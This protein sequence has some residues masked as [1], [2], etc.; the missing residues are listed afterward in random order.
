MSKEERNGVSLKGILAMQKAGALKVDIDN[1]TL[2]GV[3]MSKEQ[4]KAA[5]ENLGWREKYLKDIELINKT[6]KFLRGMQDLVDGKFLRDCLIEFYNYR[7]AN[8][9]DCY[10]RIVL[11][12][13]KEKLVIIYNMPSAGSK[14]VLYNSRV[15]ISNPVCK[16][17]KLSK[18]VGYINSNFA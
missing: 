3:K 8:S 15:D 9:L 2:A 1:E 4:A 12:S 18:I 14:Y 6:D 13:G 16:G 11:T 10:D 7:Q 17:S 5:V